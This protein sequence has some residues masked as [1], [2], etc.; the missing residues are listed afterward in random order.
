MKIL[1]ID[2]GNT[3]TK[4]GLLEDYK[5][6]D[7][8]VFPTDSIE[9]GKEEI[10]EFYKKSSGNEQIP[11]VVCSVVS[12]VSNKLIEIFGGFGTELFL[13]KRNVPLPI[14]LDLKDRESVGVDRVVGAA[15]AYERIGKCVVVGSFGTAITI[16]CVDNEGVFV[17]GVILPGLRTQARALAEYTS[18]LPESDLSNLP[19]GYPWGKNTEEA[20]SAGVIYGVAGALREIVERFATELNEWPELIITG[21]DADI[22]KEHCEFV[23]AVVPDLVLM[24]VE[25]A[26][27][28]WKFGGDAE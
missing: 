1:G 8:V 23:H 28:K 27:E 16:D 5:V 20:I 6:L 19:E 25:L 7:K 9:N 21:G 17:G 22:I 2:V 24:G 4:L 11:V 14:K 3:T 18:A 12:E 15:M 10:I 13:I 26:Y